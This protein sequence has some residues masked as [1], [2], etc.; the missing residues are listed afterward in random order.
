MD[1]LKRRG[2]N[3]WFS[4]DCF[5]EL[6][7]DWKTDIVNLTYFFKLLVNVTIIVIHYIEVK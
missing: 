4:D 6:L 2:T 5:F 7:T 3:Y 1:I